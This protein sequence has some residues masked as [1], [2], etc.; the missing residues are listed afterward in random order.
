MTVNIYDNANEM[1]QVLP[2]T[3]QFKAWQASFDAVQEDAA[4]KELFQ[5]FQ[6][7]QMTVQ[8]MMQA[9]QQPSEEQ[10]KEW[11][12]VAKQVSDNDK[13]KELMGAEKILNDLLGELNDIVTKPVAAAYQAAQA[14]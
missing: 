5:K 3:E 10:E 8:Q 4:A 2:E 1:A 14:K 13:I 7:V 11:D 12:A 6:T 9:Q